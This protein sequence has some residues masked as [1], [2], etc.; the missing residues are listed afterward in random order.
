M[1][2]IRRVVGEWQRVHA[3]LSSAQ[4]SLRR[5]DPT[6]SGIEGDAPDEL[7]AQVDRLQLEEEQALRAV[8]EALIA[9]K[10]QGASGQGAE[11][12]AGGKQA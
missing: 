11:P 5:A 10:A 2:E 6:F 8:H 9:R 7:A 4:E 3:E 12:G 1:S